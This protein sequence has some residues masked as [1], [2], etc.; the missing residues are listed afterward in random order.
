MDQH[1]PTGNGVAFDTRLAQI[2]GDEKRFP[3]SEPRK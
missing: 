1:Y 3:P 2:R